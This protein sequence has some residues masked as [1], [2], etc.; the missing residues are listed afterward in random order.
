MDIAKHNRAAW[1][2]EVDSGNL[3]TIPVSTEEIEQVRSMR[4]VIMRGVQKELPAAW[5]ENVAGKEVLCLASGGGQQ[6][7]LFAAAGA[8]V[9]LLDNS[10]G[11]LRRD[12]AV[13]QE[14]GLAIR[15][16]LGDMRDLS[17]LADASFDLIFNPISNCIRGGHIPRMAGV[18][19]RAAKR[20]G[21]SSAR[22]GTRSI[23]CLTWI[24][25]RRES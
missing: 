1:D 5:F 9:T 16:V 25:C 23:T 13:T 21:F 4:R 24:S 7:P 11:Q 20:A 14:N 15:A 17:A 19:P 12:E 22:S 3:A 10:P 6:A 18:P 8:K 2:R